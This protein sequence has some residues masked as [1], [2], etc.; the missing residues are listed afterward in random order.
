MFWSKRKFAAYSHTTGAPPRLRLI[1]RIHARTHA[2]VLVAALECL[3]DGQERLLL[4]ARE[5]ALVEGEDVNV[6]GRVLL[7]DL[8]RVVVRVERV[9]EDQRH[10]GPVRLVEPLRAVVPQGGRG[11]SCRC[12]ASQYNALPTA[13]QPWRRAEHKPT[14]R[15]IGKAIEERSEYSG[16]SIHREKRGS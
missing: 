11:V 15:T 10:L 2:P 13:S 5:A 4:N 9:H 12:R 8:G 14:N 3:C 7:D 1:T 16:A 6:G